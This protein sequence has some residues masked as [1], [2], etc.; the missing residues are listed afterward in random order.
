MATKAVAPKRRSTK[1]AGNDDS[2]RQVVIQG[3]DKKVGLGKRIAE[4]LE[5]GM[6]QVACPAGEP[7]AEGSENYKAYKFQ[8]KRLCTHL[9]RNAALP[10]RLRTGALPPQAMAAM[11][12]EA[13]MAE[14]QKSE[15]QQFRQE[16]LQEALGITAEDSAHWT[17]SDQFTCPRCEESK[18]VYIQSFKGYHSH[19][20]N[21]QEPVITIRCTSCKHLWK[22]DEVEGG[23]MAAGS[24]V[25]GVEE[26]IR[27]EAPAI[28]GQ[29]DPKESWLLPASS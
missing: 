25:Q 10:E 11:A 5:L 12:D 7:L 13:L 2:K 1:A 4:E 6:L 22:E 24:F 20:D 26:E 27:T 23:R 17:P 21:N 19:D 15:M 16:S 9:R 18:C 14:D 28:W 29:D 3:F 8:Y